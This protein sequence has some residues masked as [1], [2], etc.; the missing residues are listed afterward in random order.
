MINSVVQKLLSQIH[1][2][3]AESEQ[4]CPTSDSQVGS[5]G[6]VKRLR[7]LIIKIRASPQRREKLA[8]QCEL[9]G[10]P[11]LEALLDVRT[12][13]NSTYKMLDRANQLR[14]P[15]TTVAASE[16]DL[17]DL[18]PVDEE[19]DILAE[20]CELL[21]V[22]DDATKAI[23][24]SEYPTLADTIPLY[25]ALIDTL[26]DF[27]EER[28]RIQMLGSAVGV[29]RKKLCDKYA[30]ADAAA[31]LITTIID[32][33]VKLSYYEQEEW[34]EEWVREA[35]SAIKGVFNSYYVPAQREEV[36]PQEK[37]RSFTAM[38]AYKYRRV[39]RRNELQEYL[40]SPK[41]D[42]TPE[43]DVLQWWHGNSS[44]YP[45]LS[46][47]ARDY[48]AVPSTSTPAERVFSRG[49]ELVDERRASLGAES[50]RK[51]MCM[52]SW[53]Q[54]AHRFARPVESQRN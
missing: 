54:D 24:A 25:N 16:T 3:A 30:K 36:E 22:F 31:Y 8:R 17:R 5:L 15:L 23:C 6:C 42:C 49:A 20:I 9:A 2:E 1:V 29:A 28:T 53:V 32:P 40:D 19:W 10:V 48:L 14:A 41:A 35:K 44:A 18:A 27:T 52:Q 12:R 7:R 26:K 38:R 21:K 50:V 34:G 46:R 11:Q 4:E 51:C 39:S 33:R 47:V 43:F 13:W 37:A 45:C